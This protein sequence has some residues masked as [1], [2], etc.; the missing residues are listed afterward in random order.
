MPSDADTL[1][2]LKKEVFVPVTE[3]VKDRRDSLLHI[4]RFP[5]SGIEGWLKVE[6]ARALGVRVKKL[7]NNGPDLQL[8]RSMR[9]ESTPL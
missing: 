6:T 4:T 1:F 5:R 3:R 7:H 2:F 8:A 9:E